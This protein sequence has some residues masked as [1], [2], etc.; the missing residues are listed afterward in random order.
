MPW[1]AVTSAAVVRQATAGSALTVADTL[2]RRG[3]LRAMQPD[4]LAPADGVVPVRQSRRVGGSS[5]AL[6]DGCVKAVT[7]AWLLTNTRSI[8][9]WPRP[10]GLLDSR[11]PDG[12]DGF[13]P[14]MTLVPMVGTGLLDSRYLYGQPDWTIADTLVMGDGFVKSVVS[15]SG[16]DRNLQIVPVS[17]S[18]VLDS[19][20]WDGLTPLLPDITAP[21]PPPSLDASVT[22]GNVVNLVW[23]AASDQTISGYITSGVAQYNVRRNGSFLDSTTDLSFVDYPPDGAH[24]YTVRAQDAAGNI[25]GD[26]ETAAV[27][28]V[29]GPGNVLSNAQLATLGFISVT[30]A[31]YSADPSGIT[32]ATTRIQAAID[33]AYDNYYS[34]WIPSG[35]YRISNTLRFY[36]W[37]QSAGGSPPGKQHV[38]YG[39]TF[40]TRPVL[41]LASGASGFQNASAPRPALAFLYWRSVAASSGQSI[42]TN[43]TFN[44]YDGPGSTWQPLSA[45]NFLEVFHNVD[46][47]TGHNPGAD[48]LA[49]K[50]AQGAFLGNVRIDATSS[51]CGLQGGGGRHSPAVNIEVQGGRYGVDTDDPYVGIDG[52]SGVVFAGLRCYGQT[53]ANYRVGGFI[54]DVIVGFHFTRSS[55]SAV[56]MDNEAATSAH[57]LLLIDGTIETTGATAFVNAFGKSMYM[58]NVYVTGTNSLIQTGTQPV[59]NGTGT[60][61]RVNEYCAC[62]MDGSVFPIG[63]APT[64]SNVIA[65]YRMID[66]TIS[67]TLVAA[68]S[69]T[70][71]VAAP[72]ATLLSNHLAAIPSLDG[73][74]YILLP[75]PSVGDSVNSI[76]AAITSAAYAGHNRVAFRRGTYYVGDTIDMQAHTK[77]IGVGQTM[78]EIMVHS[79]WRPVAGNPYIIETANDANG[80]AFV[81][82]LSIIGR[83]LPN[84]YNRHNTFHWRT[85]RLSGTYGLQTDHEYLIPN[86]PTPSRQIYVF[87]GNGGGRHY[88]IEKNGRGFN[89]ADARVVLVQSTSQPLQI[90][91]LQAEITK[92]ISGAAYDPWTNVE[93]NGASNVRIYG[94]KREGSAPTV[95]MVDAHNVACY[96][97]GQMLGNDMDLGYYGIRGSS[98][99]ILV[100]GMFVNAFQSTAANWTLLEDLDTTAGNGIT[101]PHGVALYKRG[102]ID[103]E[104]MEP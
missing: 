17:Y 72:P 56:T 1:A 14:N 91:G 29:S 40:P 25:S 67:R 70:S 46:I 37:Q 71:N 52:N 47:D 49:F 66:G 7:G 23:S 36:R 97:G 4:A 74:D 92:L 85:G 39:A 100:A 96:G 86:T 34:L 28:I 82:H 13:Q 61:K 104:A 51:N 21:Y 27:N 15:A 41:Q 95:T 42:P 48:G 20:Y 50:V 101:W 68:N 60:W 64:G 11:Y 30:A 73:D 81:A 63:T 38:V 93:V 10:N 87:D 102:T 3:T 88:S 90:Y 32:D 57:T 89:G 26:S 54:P 6:T 58:R 94:G 44:P 65:H 79:S 78:C 18:G 53:V 45:N 31:P 43:L 98:D 19:R 83:S 9:A 103:D 76:N 24:T 80:T 16:L 84:T 62:D 59:V 2:L 99:G 22:G 8:R 12:V 5:L 35:T 33:Y 77:L 55:G 75:A 69:V